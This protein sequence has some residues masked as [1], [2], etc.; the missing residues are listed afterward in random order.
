MLATTLIYLSGLGLCIAAGV[1]VTALATPQGRWLTPAAPAAGAA[2]LVVL[3]QLLGFF[4]A[5]A[6]AVVL[7]CVVLVVLFGVA[8]W[9]RSAP[10][11]ET[12]ALTRGELLVLA[13]GALI[14]FLFLLPLLDIGFPTVLAAGIADGWARAVLSKWLLHNALIQ[15]TASVGAD[16]PIG[17]YSTFPHELGA[18]YEYL[19]AL[20]STVTGKQT[21]QTAL[22]VAALAG[23]IALG[24]W[25]AM[26]STFTRLRTEWWQALVLAVAPLTPVFVMPF[27]D[28]YLTQFLS[29]SLWPFAMTALYVFL[30]EPSVASA[31]LAAVG[32]GA[33]A[34]VYPPL[35]P[36]FGPPAVLMI[37]VG[38][39]NAPAAIARRALWLGLALVLLVPVVLA[40]AYEAVVLFSGVLGSNAAFP[41][42]QAEQDL[43]ILLGGASQYSFIPFGTGRTS[44]E[45]TPVVVLLLGAVG[46][47]I[48]AVWTM[49]RPERRTVA[50]LGIGV[51]GITL[52][53]YFKYKHLDEYGYGAYKAMISG[54]TLLAGLLMLSLASPSAR[55][56]AARMAAA[57][58]CVAVW[59]PLTANALQHQRN[60]NQG[61]RE[62]DNA[63]IYELD[64][65]PHKDNV[66]VEGATEDRFSFQ[67]RMTT[68]YVA[69]ASKRPFDGIGS[70]FSYFTGGGAPVW[71]PRRPW[72]Y[73]VVSDSPS[74]FPAHRKTLWHHAPYRVQEAPA[75]DVTP[76]A[77]SPVPQLGGGAQ[78]QR[79]WLPA[80]AGSV[81]EADYIGGPVEL[82]VSNRKPQPVR[83]RLS[84]HLKELRHGRTVAISA[85]DGDR[86][87]AKRVRL[88][89]RGDRN[90]TLRVPVPARGTTRVTLDPGKPEIVPPGRFAALLRLTSV[91]IR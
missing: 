30:R 50:T 45:L 67:L 4:L 57:G 5:G 3:A 44:G 81:T 6:T 56:R 53:A 52:L 90:V 75:V 37:L 68:G 7:S 2:G 27:V 55:W 82:I 9:R 54:G 38:V 80:P 49:A 43:S 69:A 40:R 13:L 91:G 10:L 14:G 48:A 87:A 23:P 58:I 39:R 35:A 47:G 12:V 22:P 20:V 65:L 60:G 28:N 86:S 36:W 63:L 61:F 83:A 25:S 42:F 31:A 21:Y 66:L 11:R 51:G 70:T 8:V 33:V 76:Y 16:R 1:A 79:Y 74:A 32:L 26:Q 59:V 41:R 71:R 19:I 18:G 34:A 24:G 72:R 62:A 84:F 46:V 88:K 78:T 89:E 85:A 64:R 17:S 15:S 73:A 29:L 77:V